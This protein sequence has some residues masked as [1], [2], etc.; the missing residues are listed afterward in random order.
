[1]QLSAHKTQGYG[2]VIAFE[3]CVCRQRQCPGTRDGSGEMLPAEP[4]QRSALACGRDGTEN[5]VH[6]QPLIPKASVS[7]GCGVQSF[8]SLAR[9]MGLCLYEVCKVQFKVSM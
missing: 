4:Q 2:V 7:L 5:C 9:K 3:G 1:M 6:L 8:W